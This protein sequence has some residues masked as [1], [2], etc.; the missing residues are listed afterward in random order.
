MKFFCNPLELSEALSVVS[1]A[2]STKTNI[3]IL[4]GIKILAEGTT[5]TLT[6]TDLELFI[7]KKIKAEIKIE[8]EVVVIGRF[9]NEFVKKLTEMSDIEIEKIDERLV[10]RYGEN[11]TEILCLN[12][13]TFPLISPVDEEKTFTIKEGDLKDI[14]ERT[15]FCVALDDTRPIL[16]GALL[17][18]KEDI[19]TAVALDGYRLAVC[20]NAVTEQKGDIR[21]IVS[22]KIL[23]EVSR[24]LEDSEDEVKVNVQ[25]NNILFDLRHTKITTRLLEGEYLQYEKIIPVTY[26]SSLI[27]KKDDLEDGLDRAS[28]IVRNKKNN[29]LKLSIGNNSITIRSNS[30]QGSIRETINCSLEGKDIEIAFNSKYL[31]DA[32]NKIKEDYIRIEFASSNAPAVIKPTEG[33][34]FKY[35][36]LPVRLLG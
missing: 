10:I 1:K 6:A 3:P 16:K 34:R 36:I 21:I 7:E 14:L 2:L 17:E 11:E 19:I 26:G 29:Y 27:V 22:G 25:K 8:G 20:R 5:L 35:I 9:F 33:D 23:N 24:I 28:I 30:E 4:E 15:L 18:I 13:S 32:L 31:F 12:E